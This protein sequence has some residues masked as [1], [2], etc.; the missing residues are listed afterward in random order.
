MNGW[1]LTKVWEID[2]RLVVARTIEDAVKL[3][4]TYMGKDYRG[5]P[6]SV[7]GISNS[8]CLCKNYE[9]LIEDKDE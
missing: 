5:E 1:T 4:K 8:V 9:A 7:V 3:Y 2:Q 6:K